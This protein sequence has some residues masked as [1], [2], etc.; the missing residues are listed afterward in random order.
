MISDILQ[1]KDYRSIKGI[2][3]DTFDST[4]ANLADLNTSW[5]GRSKD[6]SFGFFSKETGELIGF[7]ITS[8]HKTSGANIYI[9]YIALKS[10]WRGQGLGS[11]ILRDLLTQCKKEGRSVHLFPER[12]DLHA[13]YKSLGFRQTNKGFF[14][15]H[16]YE[17][18]SRSLTL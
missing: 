18:R 2:F 13:W 12:P 15:F 11:L 7:L 17:T 14:N 4:T 5:Q 3:K 1:E 16:S 9:D 8:Y 6:E 10:E